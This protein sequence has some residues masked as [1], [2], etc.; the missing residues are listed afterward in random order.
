MLE[1]EPALDLKALA[2]SCHISS[3]GLSN[4]FYQRETMKADVHAA[5]LK[6]GIPAELIPPPT[7]PKSELLRENLEL[8]ARLAQYEPQALAS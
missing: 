5:C 3:S 8:R 2:D 6:L 7:R 1:Q 4:E